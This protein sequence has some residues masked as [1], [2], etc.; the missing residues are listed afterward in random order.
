MENSKEIQILQKLINPPRID[1]NEQQ[2]YY[3][4]NGAGVVVEDGLIHIAAHTDVDFC[5]Y[6]NSF[7]LEKWSEYTKA[8]DFY[9]SLK[10]RGAGIIRIYYAHLDGG[11]ARKEEVES[12]A[13]SCEGNY[14]N[15][16][17]PNHNKGLIGFSINAIDK[18]V[19]L[20]EA[21]Y[22]SKCFD[23]RSLKIALAFTTYKREAYITENVQSILNYDDER[24]QIFVVDNGGTLQLPK[25]PR[26]KVFKNLNSGGAGGFSRNMLEIIQSSDKFTHVILMDDDVILDPNIFD[27]LFRFLSVLKEEYYDAFVGGAMFRCDHKAIHVES[28]AKW[29]GTV[30][31]PFGNGLDMRRLDNLLQTNAIHQEDYNAWW[32]CCIPVNYIREDNLPLPLFFQWDDIDYGVRNKAPLILLNGLCLWHEPFEAKRSA[33]YTY[34]STRNPLI[35]NC[36][37]GGGYS[38]KQVLKELKRKILS[39]ICLYRYE[40]A[41]A[42]IKAME[43]FMKGSKWLCSINPDEY[44]KKIL[45]MNTAM[46]YV[47]DQVDYQWYLVG[48]QIQDC[49]LLH[50]IVRVI[51]LNGY[52]LKAN[53]EIT[54][55]LYA[56][57]P[58]QG[59]RATKILFYEINSGMGFWATKDTKKALKCIYRFFKLYF[60]I[61]LSYKN[62]EKDYNENY[63]YMSSK[64]MWEKYLAI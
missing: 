21:Y 36:C 31:W 20:L 64:E 53:R 47:A 49:D 9:L 16:N 33:M 2:L 12:I 24:L 57:R 25:H 35:V 45:S 56:D 41:E 17:L 13:F 48:N 27:R 1:I 46:E 4:Y 60:R 58:V 44:N 50:H 38:K 37:H 51:T 40:H 26:L 8:D 54:V 52:L 6:F 61:S 43:D 34:Y 19:D 29:K 28:G 5:T 10:L 42:V 63:S 15:F 32:F 62:I 59:Y 3:K 55:P 7:S 39:E 23:R 30:V 22:Y 14:F 18:P 11:T